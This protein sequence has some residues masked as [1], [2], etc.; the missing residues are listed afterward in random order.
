VEPKKSQGPSRAAIAGSAVVVCAVLIGASIWLRDDSPQATVEPSPLAASKLQA[1]YDRCQDGFSQDVVDGR[2]RTRCQ[3]KVHPA[4]MMEVIGEGDEI[5]SA[6][7]L[8]P[9]RG[10]MNQLLDRMLVGLEMFSLMAGV[11]ADRFLPKEYMDA[12]GTSNTSLVFE[13]RVYTTQPV[14]NVGLVFSVTPPGAE[15]EPEPAN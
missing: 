11:R 6:K 14:A 12:I 10:S 2:T 9:L 8:V 3:T 5:E 15:P 1:L 4:F 13:D 7:M